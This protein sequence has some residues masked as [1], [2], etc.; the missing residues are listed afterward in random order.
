MKEII[1]FLI[2]AGIGS[3]VTYIL[4]RSNYEKIANEEIEEAREM[5]KE[6]LKEFVEDLEKGNVETKEEVKEAEKTEEKIDYGKIIEKLNYNEFSGAKAPVVQPVEDDKDEIDS[7]R[8]SISVDEFV[9]DDEYDKM[10]LYYF[11][12]D[13]VFTNF[14][15]GVIE[16]GEELVGSDNLDDVEFVEEGVTY[17]RNEKY[18][19]DYEVVLKTGSYAEHLETTWAEGESPEE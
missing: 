1:S 10:T 7:E 19:V 2:G 16:E 12:D 5:Y 18:G 17:I 9:N 4:I 14:E 15:Y 13:Q 11:E 8:Y 3:G 6:K